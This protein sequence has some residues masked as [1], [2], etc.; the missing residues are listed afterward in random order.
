MQQAIIFITADYKTR[1]TGKWA[2]QEKAIPAAQAAA[3][4]HSNPHRPDGMAAVLGEEED[5]RL[6]L[7]AR[8]TGPINGDEGKG[9]TAQS[10]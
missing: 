9:A 3:A 1:Y 2:W 8:A 7:A 5:A 4:T 10:T 6:G